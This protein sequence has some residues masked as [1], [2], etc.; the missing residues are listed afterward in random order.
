MTMPTLPMLSVPSGRDGAEHLIE[1]P[2][3]EMQL[4][5]LQTAA[6]G[7]LGERRQ[8]GRTGFRQRREAPITLA[9]LDASDRRQRRYRGACRLQL[10]RLL[11]LHGHCVVIARAGGEARRSVVGDYPP[12]GDDDCA[13]AD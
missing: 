7:K 11:E 1:A 12:A 6:R 9:D 3:L 5:E 2:G 13:G 8:N 4:L 10:S